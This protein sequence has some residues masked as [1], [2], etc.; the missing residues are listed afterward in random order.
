M[1]GLSRTLAGAALTLAM[2]FGTVERAEAAL[3]TIGFTGIDY[4]TTYTESGFTFVV[5]GTHTDAA[6]EISFHNGGANPVDTTLVITFGGAAFSVASFE[7]LEAFDNA[8]FLGSNGGTVT[9][10]AGTAPGIVQLGLQNVTS[11]VVSVFASG[12]GVADGGIVFDNLVV[13]AAPAAAATAVP[14]PT[15]LALLGAGLLGLAGTARRGRRA[16]N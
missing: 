5:N 13:D 3:L 7:L 4:G 15:T 9:V 1:R 6:N 2:A 14:E 16:A 10:A 11:I 12:G 8:T